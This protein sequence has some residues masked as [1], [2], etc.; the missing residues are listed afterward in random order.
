MNNVETGQSY[1]SENQARTVQ[2]LLIKAEQQFRALD[3]EGTFFT[4]ENAVAQNPNSSEA[5][6]LR[7]KFKK[8]VGMTMEAEED[9]RKANRINPLAANLYGYNGSGGLLQVLSMVPE[10]AVQE[11]STF[12]KLTYYYQAL[13]NKILD[14]KNKEA[15]IMLIGKVIEEIES[16]HL[17]EAL[18]IINNVLRDYPKSAI[19]YDLKGMILKKQGK[20]QDAMDSFSKAVVIDPG[21]AISWYNLG[22]IERS[23]NNFK[24][25]KTYLDR[26]IILQPDLTKAYFERALLLKQM[27]EKE[28]A[29]NDY[30]AIIKM[31][32]DTYMEAFLN[33]GL[34]KKMLGDY[35]GA[36]AD[37]NQAIEE[38]PNNAE[39]H[40][41]RGNLQL[42]FGL[43]R[44]AI[45]DYTRAI[46][47]DENY[48]E[49]YYNRALAFFLIYDK[50]SGCMDL[51]KSIDLGYE[52]ATKTRSY[53]CTE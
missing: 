34:T 43:H 31:K 41:N 12:Q 16:D 29:L 40:K 49:A 50:I 35:G 28:K 48:A 36:L 21:F 45:D 38:F 25:A 51:D 39:L 24:K 3:Y 20:F 53:F 8:L 17:P 27:G 9:L 46:S 18:G 1:T 2:P 7:A 22:R 13:D 10:Q 37:L 4:L 42:L 32:G 52:I 23:L 15:E 26:A 47:L 14:D 44:K 19:A 30:N 11:L 6:L 5:L 33:R